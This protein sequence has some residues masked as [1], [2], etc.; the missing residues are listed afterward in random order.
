MPQLASRIS[1]AIAE[2]VTLIL[3]L[4]LTRAVTLTLTLTPILGQGDG[5]AR[6]RLGAR[7]VRDLIRAPTRQ[8]RLLRKAKGLRLHASLLVCTCC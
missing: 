4:T 8:E 6:A 3:T 1:P 2:E 7:R 5:R